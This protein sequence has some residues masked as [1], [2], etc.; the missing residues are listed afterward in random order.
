MGGSPD[1]RLMPRGLLRLHRHR[2]TTEVPSVDGG[3]ERETS[4]GTRVPIFP[5]DPAGSDRR[6]GLAETFADAPPLVALVLSSHRSRE[7]DARAAEA[8]A[9][10]VRERPFTVRDLVTTVAAVARGG[11]PLGE[12]H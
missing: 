5:V 11:N 7:F 1:D 4:L 12:P 2:I 8:A 9:R 6:S 10:A 3:G